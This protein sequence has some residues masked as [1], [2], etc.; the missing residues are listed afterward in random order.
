M[1]SLGRVVR[2]LSLS[3]YQLQLVSSSFSLTFFVVNF[4]YGMLNENYS[5]LHVSG[6][7]LI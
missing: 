2:T 4:L 6:L 5:F 3:L 1:Q 7:V